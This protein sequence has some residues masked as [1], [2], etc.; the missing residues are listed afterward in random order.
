[1]IAFSLV[2]LA[3]M[4]PQPVRKPGE[5]MPVVA[6]EVVPEPKKT[7]PLVIPE[8]IITYH[9]VADVLGRPSLSSQ[10]EPDAVLKLLE[11][12][13]DLTGSFPSAVDNPGVLRE[14]RGGNPRAIRIFPEEHPR[15]RRD[16]ALLDAWG[17]PFVFSKRDG[18]VMEVRSAGPDGVVDTDDDIVA[19][20]AIFL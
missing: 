19:R 7:T 1:M 3:L 10:D 12:Y 20:S 17:R 8:G 18:G 9:P 11:A 2:F 6:D 5:E 15:Y 14:L 16:G 13:R 4:W